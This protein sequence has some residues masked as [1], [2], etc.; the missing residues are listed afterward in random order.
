MKGN[1]N[2]D[3]SR[4]TRCNYCHGI[5][6]SNIAVRRGLW[7]EA[8]DQRDSSHIEVINLCGYHWDQVEKLLTR[9]RVKVS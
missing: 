1:G 4:V 2:V 3:E 7:H 5:A 8:Q 6:E 9:F